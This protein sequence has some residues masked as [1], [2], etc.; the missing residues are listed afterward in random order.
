MPKEK[1]KRSATVKAG[2]SQPKGDQTKDAD[3]V[4][5]AEVILVPGPP[6]KRKLPSIR[7][8][9]H[10]ARSRWFQTRTTWPVREAPVNKLVRERG[11]VE[12]AL[13]TP[14]SVAAE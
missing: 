10:K 5:R 9:S 2:R 13:A 3:V 8:S 4:A 12:K 7:L 6:K 14:T 1:R 11:R